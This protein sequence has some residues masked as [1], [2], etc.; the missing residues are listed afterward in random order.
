MLFFHFSKLCAK[1]CEGNQSRCGKSLLFQVDFAK[2]GSCSS[3]KVAFLEMIHMHLYSMTGS[4]L[5]Y[6]PLHVELGTTTL[7]LVACQANICTAPH[8]IVPHVQGGICQVVAKKTWCSSSSESFDRRSSSIREWHVFVCPPDEW[9]NF[10][11][12]NAF[13]VIEK[14]NKFDTIWNDQNYWKKLWILTLLYDNIRNFLR[15]SWNQSR[16]SIFSPPGSFLW[17]I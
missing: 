2:A 13:L 3:K 1:I 6:W 12:T 17:R 10:H 9:R 14:R 5:A 15:N 11:V 16:F 7:L 4:R 8:K